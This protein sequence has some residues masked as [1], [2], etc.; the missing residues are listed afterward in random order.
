MPPR[1]FLLL[2]KLPAVEIVYHVLESN[3]KPSCRTVKLAAVI[4]VIY[5]NEAYAEEWEELFK[6][7][8]QL[9]IIPAEPGKIL[10][11]DAVDLPLFRKPDQFGKLRSVVKFHAGITVIAFLNDRTACK[12]LMASDIFP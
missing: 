10:Y 7:I 12:F 3:I 8:A 6:V 11:D 1:Y 9:H 5:G 4:T 2:G